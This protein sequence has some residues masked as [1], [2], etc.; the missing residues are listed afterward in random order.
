GISG[1]AATYDYGKV[2]AAVVE[3]VNAIESICSRY[4]V[5]L[6]AA[7]M[8]FVYA[9]P[10]VATLVMGAKS[11]SEVDQNVKAINETI[12]AA[13]WDALIEANLLPS[14]APLPMAAR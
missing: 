2:P 6:P 7:A 5:S 10:A 13:F 12:P 11:A 14:N 1:P 4:A 8:Q 9:H 3:K